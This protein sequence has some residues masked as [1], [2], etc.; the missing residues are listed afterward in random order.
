MHMLGVPDVR[1]MFPGIDALGAEC[2]IADSVTIFRFD[3]EPAARAIFLGNRVSLYENVR[4]VIGDPAQHPD[5]GLRIHDNVIINAFCYLSGEGGLEIA[6]EVLL[7]SH[8]RLLSAGHAIDHGDARIWRNAL[9][10]GKIRVGAG[11][12]IGAGATVLQGIEI[13]EGA[14]V[15][16]GS[17]VTRTVPP[18]GIVAGNPARLLRYRRGFEPPR[19]WYRWWR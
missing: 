3:N 16:G 9:T 7:G 12:W 2:R 8:V 10:Y 19:P 11:A 6:E 5:T 17:V 18:F 4:L 15:G 14:V 13:G 1:P